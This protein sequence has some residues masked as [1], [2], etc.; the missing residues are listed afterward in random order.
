MQES[1]NMLLMA[2][3]MEMEIAKMLMNYQMEIK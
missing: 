2:E 3:N 1:Q